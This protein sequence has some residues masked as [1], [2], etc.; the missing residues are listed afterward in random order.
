MYEYIVLMLIF[1]IIP[2]VILLIYL[3]DRINFKR[4]LLAL[5]IL[6][7]I[8]FIWDQLSVKLGI[9]DFTQDKIIGNVL[10]IPIE[11]Y[12]FFIFVPLLVIMV[13]TLINKDN[14]K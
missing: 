14:K 7:I 9:W 4:L 8:G 1:A 2:S 12:I 6:F 10:G 11:E 13:Y 5:F 3:K